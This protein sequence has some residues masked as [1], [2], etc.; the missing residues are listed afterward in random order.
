MVFVFFKFI[1][2]IIVL[3]RN[4]KNINCNDN[5]NV[6]Q[7][8]ILFCSNSKLNTH[9]LIVIVMYIMLKSKVY[10]LFIYTH[11]HI[12]YKVNLLKKTKTKLIKSLENICVE[13]GMLIQILIFK[14]RL[15]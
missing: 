9:T 10:L 5:C 12:P 1:V 4:S 7:N 8:A 15:L 11:T 14:Q 13:K 3:T 6:F 2:S